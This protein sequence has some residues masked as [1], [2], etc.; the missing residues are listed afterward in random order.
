MVLNCF[1]RILS[2]ALISMCVI[3]PSTLAM[4][5]S[6]PVKVGKIGYINLGGFK[7]SQVASNK[8]VLVNDE[9]G[10]KKNI[11]DH[12]IAKFGSGNNLLYLHY[13][14]YKAEVKGKNIRVISHGYSKFGSDNVNNTVN[15]NIMHPEIFSLVNDKMLLFFIIEDSYDLPFEDSYTL[16]GR[17]K[18]GK[19]VKY[20]DTNE[21]AK[22]YFGNS[23][24]Y[25]FKALNVKGDIISISYEI[26]NNAR[27]YAPVSK[28]EFRFKWDDK[29]QWFGIEQVVY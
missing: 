17:T 19:W 24:D 11:Y 25:G 9:W 7:F 21:I 20:F 27:Y 16:I 10:R 8:G 6:Q 18:N 28:G 5:F 23:N 2:I 13:D 22:K 29:A 12:G 26:Y 4:T 15:L 3:V 1:A 14:A